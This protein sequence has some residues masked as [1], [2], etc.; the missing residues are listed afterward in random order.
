MSSSLFEQLKDLEEGHLIIHLRQNAKNEI[1]KIKTI[2]PKNL[3]ISRKDKILFSFANKKVAAILRTYLE[4][5]Y[6]I[7][8]ADSV[9][10]NHDHEAVLHYGMTVK[11][12]REIYEKAHATE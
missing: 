8:V 12:A 3:G 7:E 9:F 11:Q 1:R 10:N 6:G 4:K 2:D 5:N